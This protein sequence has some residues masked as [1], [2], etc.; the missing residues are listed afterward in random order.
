MHPDSYAMILYPAS[1]LNLL[2]LFF[3]FLASLGFSTHIISSGNKTLLLY[4]QFEW[5]LLLFSCLIP[6]AKTSSTMLNRSRENGHPSLV[7]NLR[8]KGFSLSPLGMMLAVGFSLWPLL[9]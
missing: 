3:F 1:L 4:F 6:L 5:L 2:V 9:C 7:S 8:G